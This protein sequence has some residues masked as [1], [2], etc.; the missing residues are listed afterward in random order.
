MNFSH[1]T[2][3]TPHAQSTPIAN[4]DFEHTEAFN[5]VGKKISLLKN[6]LEDEYEAIDILW[7]ENYQIK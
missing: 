6:I 4:A 3:P 2:A 1:A 7:G 5:R